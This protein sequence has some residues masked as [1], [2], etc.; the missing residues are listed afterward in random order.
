MSIAADR[1]R[2]S[3]PSS[4]PVIEMPGLSVVPTPAPARGFWS[5]VLVCLL[6]LVA[7]FS[8]AFH[9]NTRMVQGAYEI[10]NIS[11]ELNEAAAREATLKKDVIAVATPQQL[12]ARAEGLGLVPAVGAQHI[13]L[14]TGVITAPAQD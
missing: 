9:L 6:L 10:K 12:R 4:R 14:E 3:A 1:Q 13:D 5:V 2:L 11:V 8:V 7:S